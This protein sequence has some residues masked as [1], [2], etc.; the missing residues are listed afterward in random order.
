MEKIT[1]GDKEKKSKKDKK[2]HIIKAAVIIFA[3][4]GFSGTTMNEIAVQ[5]A[6]GK[7]TIY[8]YFKS[9]ED[10]FFAV[11]EWYTREFASKTMVSI[12]S[13]GGSVTE[14]LKTM[15]DALM[16]SWEEIKDIY[17][18][19]MEFWSASASSSIRGNFKKAFQQSYQEF[20]RIV[21]SLIQEGIARG[22][23]R[24]DADPSSIAAGLVGT[25]DALL[26]Q[27]WFDHN[28]DPL[29][30]AKNYM[31]ILVRGLTVKSDT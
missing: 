22:E 19:S 17:T 9:K 16:K 21:A 12:S 6:I 29:A 18:L 20:R 4:K 27:A 7:G 10:L 15:N 3:R 13:L 25:W 23:F 26:L 24:S 1:P 14:R 30:T 31:E 8:E 2:N 11:F 5:A 28:F